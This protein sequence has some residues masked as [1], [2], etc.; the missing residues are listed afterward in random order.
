[1]KSTDWQSSY[2]GKIIIIILKYLIAPIAIYQVSVLLYN[3][4]NVWAGIAFGVCTA[5]FWLYHTINNVRADFTFSNRTTLLLFAVL[6]LMQSCTWVKP[7]YDGVL[8]TEYW[9][10]GISDFT[11]VTGKVQT[12]GMGTELIQIP[13]WEQR[14]D[15]DSVKI[16]AKDGGE[17]YIDPV[18]TYKRK[19]GKSREI[20]FNYRRFDS[21][22][23]E[24]MDLIEKEILN[25]RVVNS[26][27]DI[28]RTFSSDS[29][30]N[31][32]AM[33]EKAVE[34]ALVAVFD[35]AYFEPKTLSSGLIPPP[36]LRQRIEERNAMIQETEK[37]KNEAAKERAQLEVIRLKAEQNRALS[38]SLTPEVIKM[39]ELELE[40]QRIW[41]QNLAITYWRQA[42]CPTPQF[43]GG[44]GGFYNL[45][46]SKN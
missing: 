24:L 46:Q 44:E 11:I 32:Q 16:Y 31:N 28:A 37:V 12:W 35:S 3:F 20:A 21:S 38:Q 10:N 26:Y 30:M 13:T 9:R 23:E 36:S 5:I 33:Y 17:F 6:S 34:S 22:G 19:I 8:M 29:L 41:N 40:Q 15:L 42:G 2:G 7:Q 27:R 45:I 43:V 18:Y 25:P 39:R 14:A 1:M 4:V